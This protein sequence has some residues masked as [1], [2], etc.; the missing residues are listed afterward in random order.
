LG[1]LVLDD[2]FLGLSLGFKVHRNGCFV[3]RAHGLK[4]QGL[5]RIIFRFRFRIYD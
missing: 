4:V 2:G 1:F 3:F 5:R